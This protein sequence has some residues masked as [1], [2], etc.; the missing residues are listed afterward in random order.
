[1]DINEL[2]KKLDKIL[3]QQELILNKLDNK[4]VLESNKLI[5][6]NTISKKQI[7]KQEMEERIRII[8]DEIT[9]LGPHKRKLQKKFNLLVPPH[10]SRI[11]AYLKTNDPK[12]FD[13]LK[14][15]N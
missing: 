5:V 7:K 14:K 12:V 10:N 13:G 11:K 15:N 2:L 8:V 6:S 1:M 9:A 3:E 4:I